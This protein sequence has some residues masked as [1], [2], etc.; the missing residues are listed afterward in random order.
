MKS[1][2]ALGAGSVILAIAASSYDR[3]VARVESVA[4][5]PMAAVVT[6][7]ASYVAAPSVPLARYRATLD[8]MRPHVGAST[9]TLAPAVL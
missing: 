7:P 4:L 1:V 5:Q 3:V 2:V 8:A 6:S 9:R